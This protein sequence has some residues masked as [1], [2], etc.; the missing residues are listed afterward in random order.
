[1]RVAV[2][3]AGILGVSTA[4]WLRRD[5]ATVE[6]IDRIEP[7]SPEQTSYGNAGVLASSSIVPVAVPGL[8]KK[9][10]SMLFNPESPLFLRWSYLPRLLPF[11]HPVP[12]QWQ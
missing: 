3:G 8:V 12:R 4:E 9:I 2:I 6:L 11:A 5:G 10:P 7:G 1:M